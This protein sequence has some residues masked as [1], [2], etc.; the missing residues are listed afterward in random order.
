M[1]FL[2][3]YYFQNVVFQTK[4]FH[5]LINYATGELNTFWGFPEWKRNN[6]IWQLVQYISKIFTKL[7]TKMI[8]VNEEA[9]LLYAKFDIS[10]YTM[11]ICL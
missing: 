3:K 1:F 10:F 7:D 4:V 6:R 9:S 5:P 11:F 8:R 2:F